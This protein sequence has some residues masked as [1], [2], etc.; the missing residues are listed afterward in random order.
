MVSLTEEVDMFF[1]MRSATREHQNMV[2]VELGHLVAMMGGLTS[3][4][5]RIGHSKTPCLNLTTVQ[6]PFL[7]NSKD[8]Y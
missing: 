3:Y 6:C 5:R 1:P 7:T 2:M 8:S 4:R